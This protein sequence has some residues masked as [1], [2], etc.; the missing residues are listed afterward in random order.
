MVRIIVA[1]LIILF[2]AGCYDR[3][4]GPKIRNGFDHDITIEVEYG[5]GEKQRSIWHPCKT[6]FIG[7]ENGVVSRVLITNEGNVLYD[8]KQNDLSDLLA[9]EE[10]KKGYFVWRI[11]ADG[12]NPD[13]QQ[14]CEIGMPGPD[15]S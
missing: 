5:S 2:L 12:I 8:L 4:Y 9:K 1:F 7:K 6:A 11:G 14:H 10:E 3:F 13:T 15:F